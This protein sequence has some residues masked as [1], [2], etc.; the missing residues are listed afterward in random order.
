MAG[1]LIAYLGFYVV[2]ASANVAHYSLVHRRVSAAQRTTMV[3]I[4]SL[5]GRLGGVIAAP[6]LGAPLYLAARPADGIGDIEAEE[7]ATLWPG[8]RQR[9]DQSSRTRPPGVQEAR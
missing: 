3:S 5:S 7:R 9:P 8:A 4:N 2:H 6:A 1:L